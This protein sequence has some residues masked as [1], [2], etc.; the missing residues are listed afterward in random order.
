MLKIVIGDNE[1]IGNGKQ[2][3]KIGTVGNNEKRK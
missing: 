1:A 2:F 3:P